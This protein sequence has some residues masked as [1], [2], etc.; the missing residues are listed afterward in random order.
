M[1]KV[2]IIKIDLWDKTKQACD[3]ASYL[4]YMIDIDS[5]LNVVGE[6]LVAERW[7][8]GVSHIPGDKHV[9]VDYLIFFFSFHTLCTCVC[10][11]ESFVLAVC[12]T[13]V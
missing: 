7:V 5:T 4:C 1:K 13:S 8:D 10:V 3:C 9:T 12:C 6:Y 2:Q 11:C